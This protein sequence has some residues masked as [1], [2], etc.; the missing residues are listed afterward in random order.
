MCTWR[1]R[2]RLGAIWR[3]TRSRRQKI[4]R[5]AAF[6]HRESVLSANTARNH[7]VAAHRK[8][9]IRGANGGIPVMPFGTLVQPISLVLLL[10][11]HPAPKTRA[12]LGGAFLERATA[13]EAG[14][15]SNWDLKRP[16]HATCSSSALSLLLHHTICPDWLFS[17]GSAS[18]KTLLRFHLPA[19]LTAP[20]TLAT[21]FMGFSKT[22][23]GR[24]GG[25]TC[26]AILH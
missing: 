23:S 24:D 7:D 13:K 4:G 16:R 5:S 8:V 20:H 17:S 10:A 19:H 6:G 3:F 15:A 22:W 18:P 2:C 26:Q 21:A 12:I 25:N 14:G 11:E 1:V 9:F